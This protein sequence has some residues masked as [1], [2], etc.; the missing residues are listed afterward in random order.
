[1]LTEFHWNDLRGR[2]IY[3]AE[4]R[5]V[6]E[7][8]AVV[9]L[10][11]GLGEHCRRYDELAEYLNERGLA[12]VG[13]DRQGFGRSEGKRGHARDYA[14]YLD[15]IDQLLYHCKEHYPKVPVV[16]YG[17]SMGGQ[18]TLHY[19]IERG[20]ADVAAA[21]A[22]APHIDTGFEPNGLIVLVGRLMRRLAPGFTMDNQL[23]IDKLSRSEGVGLRYLQDPYTHKRISSRIGIDLLERAAA[24]QAYDGGMPVPTLIVH[25][26]ADGITSYRASETFAGRNGSVDFKGFRGL[27]H[28]LHN[29]PER[30]D[31]LH[32]ITEWIDAHLPM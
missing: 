30:E 29:E 3:A 16:L 23:D 19:L 21:V 9:A 28:E 20:G 12:V 25:G 27:F 10:I 1:M 15:E 6:T 8:R 5:P 18:L 13:Y 31:V 14:D 7:A 26:D 4:W 17:Q 24:L 2:K 22:T 32:Y 11:H